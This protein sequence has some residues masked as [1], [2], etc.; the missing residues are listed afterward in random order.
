MQVHYA[1][2]SVVLVLKDLNI[3]RIELWGVLRKMQHDQDPQKLDRYLK[4]YPLP[5][6]A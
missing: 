2:V 4:V 5:N 6:G 1:K 3:M